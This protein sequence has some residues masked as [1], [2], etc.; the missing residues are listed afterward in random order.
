[1]SASAYAMLQVQQAKRDHDRT[2]VWGQVGREAHIHPDGIEALGW[3]EGD[4]VAGLRVV[5]DAKVPR[6]R[7][8]VY[9]DG[10]LHDG[11]DPEVDES[12]DADATVEE[13]GP[14]GDGTPHARMMWFWERMRPH[15]KLI[16]ELTGWSPISSTYRFEAAIADAFDKL[17]AARGDTERPDRELAAVNA[18]YA[19]MLDGHGNGRELEDNFDAARAMAMAAINAYR[20]TEQEHKDG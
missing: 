19:V 11:G 18:A 14:I 20:D 15:E 9:C 3:E 8:V 13:T 6:R 12:V 7:V 1:M 17:V 10:D 16:G 4:V 2:C 5:A